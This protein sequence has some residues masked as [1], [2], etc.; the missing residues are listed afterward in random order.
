MA[1][2]IMTQE[3]INQ[4]LGNMAF[5]IMV[6]PTLAMGLSKLEY[7]STQLLAAMLHG[8]AGEPAFMAK[9]A[10]SLASAL[11]DQWQEMKKPPTDA[12]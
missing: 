5:P 6:G 7:I 2:Q 10:C 9:R 8:P 4:M 1:N 11:I 3:K 12:N